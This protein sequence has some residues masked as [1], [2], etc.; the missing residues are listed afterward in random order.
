MGI[1]S[2]SPNEAS[3][4]RGKIERKSKYLRKERTKRHKGETMKREEKKV[5]SKEQ[6][7]YF[8]SKKSKRKEG[9]RKSSLGKEIFTC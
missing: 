2:G 9:N 3:K 7:I 4:I 6:R 8:H 5:N 1:L